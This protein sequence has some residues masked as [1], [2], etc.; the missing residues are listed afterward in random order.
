MFNVCFQVPHPGGSSNTYTP[1]I[2][3][4]VVAPLLLI[5]IICYCKLRSKKGTDFISAHLT[6]TWLLGSWCTKLSKAALKDPYYGELILPV[7]FDDSMSPEVT[8]VLLLLC[9]FENVS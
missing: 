5:A 2:V 7:N 6:E 3:L 4:T 1:V 9:W 8:S